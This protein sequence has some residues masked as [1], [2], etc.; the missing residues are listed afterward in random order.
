METTSLTKVVLPILEWTVPRLFVH[1]RVEI[2]ALL[3]VDSSYICVNFLLEDLINLKRET[4]CSPP[5]LVFL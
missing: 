2:I 5:Q 1:P 4:R 3:S